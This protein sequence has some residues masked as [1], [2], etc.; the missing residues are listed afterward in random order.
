MGA[1]GDDHAPMDAEDLGIELDKMDA[2]QRGKQQVIDHAKVEKDVEALLSLAGAGKRQEAIDGLLAIEKQGRL[3]EDITSTRLA[4]CTILQV[5][6]TQNHALSPPNNPIRT[7]PPDHSLPRS[8]SSTPAI[9]PA[10]MRPS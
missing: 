2:V 10:S 8:S 9:G 6:T 4:C 1:P 7:C 3:A 5:R